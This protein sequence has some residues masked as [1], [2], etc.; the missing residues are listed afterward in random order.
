MSNDPYKRF[1]SSL[2]YFI[3]EL[4]AVFPEY[5]IFNSFHTAYKLLKTLSKKFPRKHFQDIIVKQFRENIMK[6]D[7][8]FFNAIVFR[9]DDN[10]PIAIKSIIK[11]LPNFQ[12]IW[13][14]IDMQTKKTIWQHLK[15]LVVLSDKC[16]ND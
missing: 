9:Q 15:V 8:S 14:S 2:K 7:E 13:A 3:R 5:P 4:I 10:L 11:D 1:N 12:E 6:E 16:S